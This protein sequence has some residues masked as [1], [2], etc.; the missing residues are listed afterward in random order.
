LS[1]LMHTLDRWIKSAKNVG[2]LHNYEETAQRKQ[3][4]I[5]LKF[6]QSGHPA[7]K[8][9]S[10]NLQQ[11]TFT[12]KNVLNVRGFMSHFAECFAPGWKVSYPG[13]SSVTQVESL[14]NGRL[15]NV[16]N[17]ASFPGTKFRTC[18]WNLLPR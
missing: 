14:W 2:Y 4:T 13:A 15:K 8:W 18:V 9:V 10:P 12:G 11:K 16:N 5:G 7:R 6:G 1:K 3:S 17:A